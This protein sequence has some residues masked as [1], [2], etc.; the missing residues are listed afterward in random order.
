MNGVGL[1]HRGEFQRVFRE[2]RSYVNSGVVLYV[3]PRGGEGGG[4][5]EAAPSKGLRVAFSV[6]KK[7]GGA[8]VRNRARRLLRESFRLLGD[9][10]QGDADLVF[11]GRRALEGVNCGRAQA[12][13]V[14][15]LRRAGLMGGKKSRE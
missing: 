3:L 6:G 9:R 10:V 15:L 1:R 8:V 13:M 7:L 11:V 2:G 14:D 5:T 4:P 12:A